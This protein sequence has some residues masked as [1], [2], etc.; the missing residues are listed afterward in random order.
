M[1]RVTSAGTRR[2]LAMALTSAVA[3]VG[4]GGDAESRPVPTDLRVGLVANSLG[5]PQRPGQVQNAALDTGVRRLREEVQ[6][7]TV[8]PRPGAREWR[9]SDRLF[10]AAARRHIRLLPLL[11]DAPAWAVPSDGGLPTAADAYATFVRD[12]VDRYGRDGTFWRRRPR[13]DRDLAPRWFELWNEPYFVKEPPDSGEHHPANAERYAA[14]AGD[15]IAATRRDG[16]DVRFLL[17]A[18][19]TSSTRPDDD[20]LWLNALEF[21]RPGLL[22]S[23]D[24]FAAHPYGIVEP[25]GFRPLDELLEELDERSLNQ[26][27]WITEIGWSTCRGEDV[28]VSEEDQADNLAAL[29]DG[30]ARRYRSTVEALFVYHLYDWRVQ[31][32]GGREGAFGLVRIGG[33]RKPAFSVLQRYAR[34]ARG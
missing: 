14:L 4:C 23:A 9:V 6:W 2:L 33:A 3:L 25:E 11:T 29:F 12:A 22:Q 20:E 26:P 16:R 21:A 24:A 8:E 13:L 18:A 1:E 34:V 7:S 17:S 5:H 19:T 30:L 27:V 28:C 10:A 15:A 31:P 32:R